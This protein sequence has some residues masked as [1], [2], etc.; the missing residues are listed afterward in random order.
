MFGGLNARLAGW[1]KVALAN[2]VRRDDHINYG[3]VQPGPETETGVPLVRVA[4]LVAGDFSQQ[5]LKKIDPSIEAQYKRSR[6]H[7]DEIL[8]ACVGSVGAVAL[9]SPRLAGAN[10]ARAVA[11]VRIDEKKASRGYVAEFLR[12]PSTQRYFSAETRTVAQPTLNIKQ[13]AETPLI[14]PPLEEQK[15]FSGRVDEIARLRSLGSE[16]LATL[17]A[18]FASLRHRAFEGAL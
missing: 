10:I 4:N 16:H 1:P 14:L 11:R 15:K 5:S 3:V 13:L 7:G 2:V 9:A 17:D 18:L 8:V 12:L 6:L